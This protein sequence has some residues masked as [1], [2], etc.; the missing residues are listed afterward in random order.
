M[1]DS[2]GVRIGDR[3]DDRHRET[4]DVDDRQAALSSQHL[5]QRLAFDVLEDQELMIAEVPVIE[6]RDDIGMPELARDASLERNLRSSRLVAFEQVLARL[7]RVQELDR[8]EP[9]E[10]RIVGL[11]DCSLHSA[12]DAV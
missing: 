7:T 1:H 3:V 12:A 10:L 4:A 9:I 2:L 11:E 5:A 6:D 8:N